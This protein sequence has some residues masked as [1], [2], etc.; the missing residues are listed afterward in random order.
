MMKTSNRAVI[1]G[2][3]IGGLAAAIALERSGWSV[4]VLERSAF[5]EVGAGISLWPNALR[6]LDAL[7]LGEQ[8]R[9]RS[10]LEGDGG[11]RRS[12]GEWL[13]R[14]DAEELARRF[15]AMVVIHRAEL[16]EI[17]RD[18]APSTALHH[19][20]EVK[21]VRGHGSEI[22]VVH[23][24]G[25]SSGELVV[26]A[27]GIGSVVRHSTFASAEPRYAGYT[28]WRFVAEADTR[29]SSGESWGRGHRFG[30]APLDERRTY[31]F[32]T[33]NRPVGEGGP[34]LE[35]LRRIF[36]DWHDPIP[37]LLEAASEAQ[38][39]RNDIFDLPPLPSFASGRVALLG[40]AAHAMSP[41]LGQGACQALEDAVVLAASLGTHPSVESALE[42]YDDQRRPRTQRIASRSRRIGQIAQ[43]SSRPAVALRDL[44]VRATPNSSQ[45]RSLAPVL[46]WEPPDEK[47]S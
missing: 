27:D 40:D 19:G 3:G 26:G 43:W 5:E 14:T 37:A 38:I 18:A 17:L 11:I 29:G 10:A 30:I 4:E 44:L 36:G 6:A 2:G 33:A 8:V 34:K 39:L 32:A 25:V 28:A 31:A 20:V 13:L 35:E 23:S 1:V 21:D 47:G 7:G 9:R 41:D 42:A 12:S 16:L 24:Q 15:G 22:E 46:E 45:L